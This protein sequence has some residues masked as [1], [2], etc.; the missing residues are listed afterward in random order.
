MLYLDMFHAASH[1]FF[2]NCS[3]FQWH[4]WFGADGDSFSQGILWVFMEHSSIQFNNIHSEAFVSSVE[5]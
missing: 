3:R 5:T 2:L 4:P 1:L